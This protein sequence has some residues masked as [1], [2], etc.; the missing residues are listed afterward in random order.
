MGPYRPVDGNEST[1][2]KS[3]TRLF[4]NT[5]QKERDK[6]KHATLDPQYVEP[7]FQPTTVAAARYNPENG[8]VWWRPDGVISENPE[9]DVAMVRLG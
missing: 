4:G 7:P 3:G 9:A 6:M 5:T 8:L 1:A 2:Q